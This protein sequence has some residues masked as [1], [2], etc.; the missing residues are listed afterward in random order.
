LPRDPITCLRRTK[1]K[2]VPSCRSEDRRGQMPDLLNINARPP[3]AGD[4]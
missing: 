2:R 4:R 3:K 1:V